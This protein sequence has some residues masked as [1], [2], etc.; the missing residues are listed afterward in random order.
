MLWPGSLLHL[1]NGWASVHLSICLSVHPS[2]CPSVCPSLEGR[3]HR[4]L[5]REFL[6]VQGFGEGRGLIRAG[7]DYCSTVGDGV[8]R[9]SGVASRGLHVLPC[10][11]VGFAAG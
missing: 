9:G 5:L 3:G 11:Q 6:G 8:R 1:F 7:G 10:E 4:P 2:I